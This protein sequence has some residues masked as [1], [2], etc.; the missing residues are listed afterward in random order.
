MEPTE[1]VKPTEDEHMFNSLSSA[2]A[3]LEAQ[4]INDL[5][6]PDVVDLLKGS[7]STHYK[8]LDGKSRQTFYIKSQHSLPEELSKELEGRLDLQLYEDVNGPI[9]S[10]AITIA[11]PGIFVPEVTHVLVIANA[12]EIITI[13]V[14]VNK[15]DGNISFYQTDISVPSDNLKML[16]MCG[17]KTGRIF[18]AADDGYLYEFDYK[19]QES[20]FSR[21]C[22]KICHAPSKLSYFLS[23][24]DDPI[25]DLAVDESRNML[26][27]L[28]AMHNLRV[29][30][31]GPDGMTLTNIGQCTNIRKKAQSLCP[32]SRLFD[33]QQF[34]IISIHPIT[35]SGSHNGRL[36]AVTSNGA[37]LYFTST[38][39]HSVEP[40]A[41]QLTFVRLPVEKV[42]TNEPTPAVDAAFYMDGIYMVA[43][44]L[45]PRVSCVCP[46]SALMTEGQAKPLFPHQ[47]MANASEVYEE[48]TLTGKICAIAEETQDIPLS[49]KLN[50][51]T[52][53][54][55]VP[56]RR[57]LVQTRTGLVVVE[58]RRPIE[59]LQLLIAEA[60][61]CFDT[62]AKDI[63]DFIDHYGPAQ[64]YT[65]CF[66]LVCKEA[67]QSQQL[68][69]GTLRYTLSTE[70][71]ATLI[72]SQPATRLFYSIDSPS[73]IGSLHGKNGVSQRDG[74]AL[75]LYRLL[76]P[77]W[78]QK[79]TVASSTTQKPS[80]AQDT[81]VPK[82]TLL[83]IH[84]KLCQ[85]RKFMDLN[86]YINPKP[87]H[88]NEVQSSMEELYQLLSHAIE[89][90]AFI[91]YLIDAGFPRIVQ[92]M[93]VSA[94]VALM[95][96]TYESMLTK[97]DGRT[98]LRHLVTAVVDSQLEKGTDLNVVT[99]TLQN[100]C[101]MLTNPKEVIMYKAVQHVRK[102][103]ETVDPTQRTTQLSNSLTLFKKIADYLSYEQL[104]EI[105]EGYKNLSYNI[106]VVDLALTCA[107]AKD[108]YDRCSSYV[109]EGCPPADSRRKYYEIKK[110]CY[111][112]VFSAL[113]DA[114]YAGELQYDSAGNSKDR[115][116]HFEL[117]EWFIN[118]GM[119]K[120]LL[121]A[122]TPYV[123]PFLTRPPFRKENYDLLWQHY[124]L[125]QRYDVAAETLEQLALTECDITLEK[126][127]E[128]LTLAI[129]CAKSYQGPRV[130]QMMDMVRRL[131]I[132]LQTANA[133]LL[134][135]FSE[136]KDPLAME[137]EV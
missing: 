4:S 112:C 39:S 134:H 12:K 28:T 68:N 94:Q 43:D 88:P 104:Q 14:S 32:T 52:A 35:V 62:R 127:T 105:C 57:F 9:I 108:P 99:D 103:S 82:T 29:A 72:S 30:Y 8:I 73:I 119:I 107:Q 81:S 23:L 2:A 64:T 113:L 117:Y 116:F 115:A 133:Q 90:V 79:V 102:A 25:I 84:G 132:D 124:R 80:N 53:S 89:A 58:K 130:I 38:K 17:T 77:I 118:K 135:N 75:Y 111:I 122:N 129:G 86:P 19:P 21:R 1:L 48:F 18:M 61:S 49:M 110:R 93:S 16:R 26:Y 56:P 96:L 76:Q 51:L 37:R 11:K 83:D 6:T 10:V 128:Y 31:L 42:G 100:C 74:F 33:E 120:Q 95:G 59:I 41:L 70:S 27:Q 66:D 126:R 15:E 137:T 50:E 78:N 87:L 65:M 125:Q 5:R 101:G 24:Y 40:A 67:Q 114:E 44:K 54:S 13:G 136:A 47:N 69:S 45:K 106:G 60:G 123:V 55:T 109:D 98:V 20:W 34:D 91:S 71:L 131:E 22:T 36:L 92:R 3:F 85:L 7:S 63:R 46:D 121:T 97:P